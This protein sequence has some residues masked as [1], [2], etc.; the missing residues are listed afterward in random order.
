MNNIVLLRT[1]QY[2]IYPI[3]E[4][5]HTIIIKKNGFILVIN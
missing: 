5:V 4:M 3:N 2:N 1:V